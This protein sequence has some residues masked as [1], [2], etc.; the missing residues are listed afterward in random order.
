M[1][2]KA[3]YQDFK[4]LTQILGKLCG[5]KELP[6]EKRIATLRSAIVAAQKLSLDGLLADLESELSDL[7]RRINEHL[8]S[9]RERLLLAAREARVPHKRFGQ[10]DR[11]GVFKVSYKG[12]K[13]RLEVGSEKV[14]EFAEGDGEKIFGRIQEEAAALEREPFSREGFLRTIKDACRIARE[15]GQER[16]G[17]VQVR[18]LH[19]YVALLRHLQFEDFM[20]TPVAKKFRD[21]SSAQF[22]YDLARFGRSGWSLGDDMLR[23]MTPN[24]ATVSAGKAITLPN[25]ESVDTLGPQFAVLRVEKKGGASGSERGSGETR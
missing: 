11:V 1:E 4:K 25:L 18:V 9:R 21:Y 20:K 3:Q 5:R 16:D 6:D 14:C 24:M 23:T 22:A 17:W 19:G 15:R 2:L 13:V 8:T 12:M 10:Y 7:E